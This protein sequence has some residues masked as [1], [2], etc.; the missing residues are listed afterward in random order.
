MPPST[1]EDVDAHVARRVSFRGDEVHNDPAVPARALRRP[2]A[3]P[4]VAFGPDGT[5][6]FVCQAFTSRPPT[7]LRSSSVAR[8]TAAAPGSTARRNK[9]TQVNTWNGNGKSKGSNGQF[10]TTSPSM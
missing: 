1:A 9:L 6:Y 8:G 2:A 3:N 10:P 5:V 7:R 4:A